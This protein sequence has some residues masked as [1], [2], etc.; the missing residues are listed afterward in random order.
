MTTDSNVIN[1][2]STLSMYSTG[3]SYQHGEAVTSWSVFNQAVCDTTRTKTVVA[4]M[5]IINEPAHNYKTMWTIL[6]THALGQ[7]H[8]VVTFNEQLYCKAKSLGWF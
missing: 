8:T 3:T 7:L 6:T 5:P 2:V 1:G 4:A